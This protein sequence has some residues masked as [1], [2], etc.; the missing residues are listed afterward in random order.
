MSLNRSA[1]LLTSWFLRRFFN[2]FYVSMGAN[3]PGFSGSL[4]VTVANLNPRGMIGRIK[5]VN[6]YA[7]LHTSKYRSCTCASWIHSEF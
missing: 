5:I 6:H 7:L 1:E 4:G 3:D 2:I